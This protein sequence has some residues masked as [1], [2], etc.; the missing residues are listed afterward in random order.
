ME[1]EENRGLVDKK[2]SKD[3]WARLVN[4]AFCQ[5]SV[6]ALSLLSLSHTLGHLEFSWITLAL[7]QGKK[8]KD[9]EGKGNQRSSKEDQDQEGTTRLLAGIDLHV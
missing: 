5:F 9:K 8:R 4:V 7:V 6:G 1:N 2:A 3:Q